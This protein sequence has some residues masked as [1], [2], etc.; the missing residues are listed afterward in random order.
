[1]S[2]VLPACF[3]NG[4]K[5]LCLV[6]N[7]AH[8][9]ASNEVQYIPIE[10]IKVG[11]IVRT[12][13]QGDRAV[14]YISKQTITNDVTDWRKSMYRCKSNPELLLT[15][16]NSVFFNKP[17]VNHYTYVFG[18]YGVFAANSEEF[19]QVQTDYEYDIYKLSLELRETE[20]KD[21]SFIVRANDFFVELNNE[22]KI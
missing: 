7:E 21:G 22:I 3:G 4:V 10:K 14:K 1:M 12:Y 6:H 17:V 16:I 18:K 5:I 8:N 13:M 15:G 9:E 20:E 11:D 19:A 2:T